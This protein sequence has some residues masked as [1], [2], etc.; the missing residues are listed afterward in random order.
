LRDYNTPFKSAYPRLFISDNK[1]KLRLKPFKSAYPR[2][3]ISDNKFKLRL[4]EL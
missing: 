2:L 4:N 3:F 1:F